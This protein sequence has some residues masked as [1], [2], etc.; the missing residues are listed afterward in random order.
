MAILKINSFEDIPIHNYKG[1]LLFLDDVFYDQSVANSVALNK[2]V[3]FCLSDNIVS[4]ETEFFELYN[5]SRREIAEEHSGNPSENSRL[6]YFLR[7]G[8]L[9][10]QATES[11]FGLQ[12]ESLYW[13]TFIENIKPRQGSTSFLESLELASI[14]S[15]SLSQIEARIDHQKLIK[16]GFSQFLD[17]VL[18][19]EELISNSSQ[20]VNYQKALEKIEL[21]ASQVFILGNEKSRSSPDLPEIDWFQVSIT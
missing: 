12:I 10:W 14:R 3:E 8:E 15:C 7:F 1:A 5:R 6:L 13:N 4:T 2:C 18:S 19:A 16:L 21:E 20:H 9:K 17:F 11:A